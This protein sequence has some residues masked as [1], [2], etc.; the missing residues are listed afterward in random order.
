MCSTSAICLGGP[1]NGNTCTP[2]SS[3]LDVHSCCAGGGWF[4]FQPC[5]TDDDCGAGALRCELSFDP[6]TEDSDC[7]SEPNDHCIR[8]VPGCTGYPTS[9]DCPPDPSQD[10][11]FKIGGLPID[12]SLT[13]ELNVLEA[14]DLSTS[15]RR[16]FCGYCRDVTGAGTLCFEGDL[17]PSCPAA[18]PPADGNGVPCTSNA[19]C[20]ANRCLD[21]LNRGDICTDNSD[22]PGSTCVAGTDEYETCAQR[23]P[24]AFSKA[25]ATTFWSQ[26]ETDGEWLSDYQ[27]HDAT[28]VGIFC[29]PPTFDPTI[30]AAG[31]LP[32]PAVSNLMG[33]Q[34]IASTP[35]ELD[36]ETSGTI[37]AP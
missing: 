24:G 20:Q 12:F 29:I 16:A 19:D 4:E 1:D 17:R 23:N 2:E 7:V 30:D 6:C 35:D 3:R 32:G 5:D 26:G 33:S 9:H 11:T 14:A 27:C 18:I 36:P 21:G 28:L 34:R 13:D 15:G 10:I 25:A 8:C 22:C 31:D 37:C